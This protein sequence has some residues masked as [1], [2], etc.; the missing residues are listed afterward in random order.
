MVRRPELGIK[1][2][3]CGLGSF[4]SQFLELYNAHPLVDEVV[5]ADFIRDRAEDRRD[6][7]EDR[8]DTAEDRRDRAED[9]RD[10][11]H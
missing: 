8:R 3:I 10:A 4:G 2:G 5:L 1:I 6:T 9:R 11:R 7:A